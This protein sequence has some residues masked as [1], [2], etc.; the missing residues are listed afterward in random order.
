MGIFDLLRNSARPA[1]LPVMAHK[2]YVR[3][4]HG[5]DRERPAATAWAAGQAQD[6]HAWGRRIDDALWSRAEAFALSL[7][8]SAEPGVRRLA[9][10]GVRLGGPGGIELL[11]FLTLALRPR[12][13]VETGVAA[14]WSTAA[15]LDAMR[16]NMMGHLYSSDFPCFRL[17]DA[18]RHIGHVVPERLKDR[19]TLH[20]RGD[21]RNLGEI[22]HPTMRVD[23]VHYDSDKTRSGRE[24]FLDRV[25]PHLTDEHV[26]VMDDIQDNLVFREYARS[27]PFHRVFAYQGKF[28]GVTGPG[29]C[30]LERGGAISTAASV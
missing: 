27:Q 8:R 29:L 28:I 4:R 3:L 6:L 16:A 24:F 12:V 15:V 25:A 22:L 19:W 10:A 30:A 9:A 17:P 11:H 14:G 7:T 20:I 2:A 26:L 13:V 23:L 1:H 21:R 18:E 5:H